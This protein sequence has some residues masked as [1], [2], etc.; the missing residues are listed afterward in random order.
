MSW[1]LPPYFDSSNRRHR[2]PTESC[3][4]YCHMSNIMQ[5]VKPLK[6]LLLN[7]PHPC[8][9]QS[10]DW[11]SLPE[12]FVIKMESFAFAITQPS[13]LSK[14]VWVVIFHCTGCHLN[15]ITVVKNGCICSRTAGCSWCLVLSFCLKGNNK[16]QIS[17]VQLKIVQRI[18]PSNAQPQG[19][20]AVY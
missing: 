11:T 18:V 9:L 1:W 20:G 12:H 6:L 19:K 5:T 13:N 3:N 16:R 10:L 8:M 7:I 14:Q 15:L 4:L 2:R 17:D